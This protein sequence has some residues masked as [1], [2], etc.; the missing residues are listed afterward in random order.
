VPEAGG[1]DA[2]GFGVGDGGTTVG[3]EGESDSDGAEG[4][5]VD[6]DDASPDGEF[7]GS[8]TTTAA[9]SVPPAVES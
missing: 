1:L 9:E 6:P 7:D 5:V 8:P 2:L 3:V 4:S